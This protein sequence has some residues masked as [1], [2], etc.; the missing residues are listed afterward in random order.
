[1]I[2]QR[3][4]KEILSSSELHEKY[5]NKGIFKNGKSCS[6]RKEINKTAE[7]PELTPM[8]LGHQKSVEM[9]ADKEYEDTLQD[10]SECTVFENREK[11]I[12]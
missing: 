11:R 7:I 8:N 12:F 9:L 4:K 10:K 6:C 5:G 3:Q 1:M 2:R